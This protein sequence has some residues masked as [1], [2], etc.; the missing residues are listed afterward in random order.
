MKLSNW[1]LGDAK[2]CWIH[3]MLKQYEDDFSDD[4]D[5]EKKVHAQNYYAS[6]KEDAVL[7]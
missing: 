2:Y 4:D 7:M 1:L 3:R 6:N 5:E